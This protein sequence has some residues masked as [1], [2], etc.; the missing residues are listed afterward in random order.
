M[1]IDFG[2]GEREKHQ[3][4]ASSRAMTRAECKL[5]LN[6]TCLIKKESELKDLLKQITYLCI[7]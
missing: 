4:A 2:G 3:M 5:F 6:R 1:F 7:Q